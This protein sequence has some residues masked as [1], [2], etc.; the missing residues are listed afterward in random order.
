MIVAGIDPGKT[1]ALFVY[2]MDTGLHEVHDVPIVMLKVSGKKTLRPTPLYDQWFKEWA[3]VLKGVGHIYIEKVGGGMIGGTKQ[4][5][6][7]MF[8]FGYMAAFA[9]AVAIHSRVPYTFIIPQTW[10]KRAGI[11]GS[12]DGNLSRV[13]ASQLIPGSDSFWP[14]KKHDGRAEAALIAWA[15]VNTTV[16]GNPTSAEQTDGRRTDRHPKRNSSPRKHLKGSPRKRD[17]AK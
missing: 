10:R 6:S 3:A 4:S 1:G 12:S 16:E 2:D 13:R 9:H 14:L 15:G 17:G 11:S 8:G 7:S 5:G